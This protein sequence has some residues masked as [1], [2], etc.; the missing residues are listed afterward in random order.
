MSLIDDLVGGVDVDGALEQVRDSYV[1][2]RRRRRNSQVAVVAA[3]VVLVGGATAAVW[4]TTGGDQ[5]LDVVGA[6][7]GGVTPASAT[8][9]VGDGMVLTL[10]VDDDHVAIGLVG[11]MCTVGTTSLFEI[12]GVGVEHPLAAGAEDAAPGA[13]QK[14]QVEQPRRV[15][16]VFEADPLASHRNGKGDRSVDSE[17]GVRTG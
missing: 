11:E 1:R 3:L 12:G 2:S 7:S 4:R 16:L 15:I 10:S 14:G 5:S 13:E 17:M 6:T 9:Q 8:V